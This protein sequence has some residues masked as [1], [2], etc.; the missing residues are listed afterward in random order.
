MAKRYKAID[1]KTGKVIT[2][3][4]TR[5]GE[6]L[7]GGLV[8]LI[9]LADQMKFSTRSTAA[10][11]GVLKEAVSI[12]TP[13]A[14]AAAYDKLGAPLP[15]KIRALVLVKPN[16][17]RKPPARRATKGAAVAGRRVSAKAR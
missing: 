8:G 5:A 14:L 1:N 13:E 17:A 7:I 9:S 6:L 12:A 3:S 4:E 16:G 2:F 10:L 15:P 11:F